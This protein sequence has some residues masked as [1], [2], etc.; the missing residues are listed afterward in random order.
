MI[1]LLLLAD[2]FYPS[3][4]RDSRIE[5]IRPYTV[6]TSLD[7]EEV[8]FA[9]VSKAN[10][11][12][13]SRKTRSEIIDCIGEPDDS[14]YSR[15]CSPWKTST[16]HAQDHDGRVRKRPEGRLAHG[17][18]KHLRHTLAMATLR[19]RSMSDNLLQSY[20]GLYDPD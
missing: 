18:L 14:T 17:P 6:I 12:Q 20:S 16:T 7:L 15:S 5:K 13:R 19:Y 9:E 3:T 1:L 8:R 4:G 2:F 10:E 11:K